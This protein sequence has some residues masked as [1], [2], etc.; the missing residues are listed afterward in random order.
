MNPRY[1]RQLLL[2]GFGPEGQQRLQ[3]ARVLVVGAGGLGCPA[4]QYL[5]AAGVGH[6]AVLDADAVSLT[7]LHR[8]ILYT[9]ADVGQ[10]K[11]RVAAERLRALNPEVQVVPIAEALSPENALHWLETAHVVLD[12]SDNFRTRYLVNDACVLLGKPLVYGSV[13]QYEGQWA[14][15]DPAAGVQLRDV[16]PDV[17]ATADDCSTGGVLGPLPGMVGAAQA[18]LALQ[19][20]ARVLPL[21]QPGQASL[22]VFDGLRNRTR[23]IV[24]RPAGPH[25]VATRET[26]LAH[27]QQHVPH[28]VC[29]PASARTLKYDDYRLHP[30]AYTLLDVREPEERSAQHL[31]GLHIPLRE[32]MNRLAEL[33]TH[34]PVLVYCQAGRRSATIAEALNQRG[35]LAY[36]LEGGLQAAHLAR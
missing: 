22:T 27:C 4:L 6:L 8:Q 30:D 16:F 25:P 34:L 26:W 24:I 1:H 14:L 2:P 36:S 33:P 29:E 23:S 5:A 18:L 32:V 12:G 31:G 19:Y 9:P 17:P 11:V 20:L 10:L 28:E 15:F 3:Q 7:N 21:A 13:Y 35:W